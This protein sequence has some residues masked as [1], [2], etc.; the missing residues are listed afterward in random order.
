M[1]ID[2]SVIIPTFRRP[3]QLKRAVASALMQSVGSIEVVVVDDSPEGSAS[4][5]IAALD[6]GRVTYHKMPVPTGGMPGAV[7]NYGLEQ[8]VGTF[9]H[10][11]DDDDEVPAGHYRASMRE[12]EARPDVGFVFGRIEP[13][14]GSPVETA[15]EQR[16]W[17]AAARRARTAQR[18]GPRLGFVAYQLFGPTLL[19]C[20][21]AFMRR[22]CAFLEFDAPLAP[23]ED[24]EFFIRVMRRFGA[25]WVDRVTL[26]Y[27]LGHASAMHPDAAT[28]WRAPTGKMLTDLQLYGC[29]SIEK[30]RS[31]HGSLELYALKALATVLRAA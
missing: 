2:V 19:L 24:A 26:R 23:F 4:D 27:G 14:G 17:A 29:K 10:F 22:K 16:E 5:A 20:G 21:A 28:S 11:L 1:A 9:I 12:L 8:S 30:Y 3:E 31:E 15:R 13:F 25:L 6:D 18:L 7:R